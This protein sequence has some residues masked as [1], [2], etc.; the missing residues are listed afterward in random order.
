MLTTLACCS[1]GKGSNFGCVQHMKNSVMPLAAKLAELVTQA[2][3]DCESRGLELF[4]KYFTQ[5]FT[6]LE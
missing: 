2:A 3:I 6:E 4:R 1:G 5:G